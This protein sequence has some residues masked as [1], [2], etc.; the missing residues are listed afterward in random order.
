M[1]KTS[2]KPFITAYWM[3]KVLR[4]ET[5]VTYPAVSMY[6]D[7]NTVLMIS[8]DDYPKAKQ[9]AE[10]LMFTTKWFMDV[11]GNYCLSSKTAMLTEE[12]IEPDLERKDH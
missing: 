2:H 11:Y 8:K 3:L 10:N 1:E 9:A 5:G 7:G 12:T 4:E 6:E